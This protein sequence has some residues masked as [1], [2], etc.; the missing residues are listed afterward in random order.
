MARSLS[1]LVARIRPLR[2]FSGRFAPF[3]VASLGLENNSRGP[4]PN[5][6]HRHLKVTGKHETKSLLANPIRLRHILCLQRVPHLQRNWSTLSAT[7]T[8]SAKSPRYP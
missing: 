5:Y 6:L 7:W 4:S 2:A 8:T 3:A 1:L